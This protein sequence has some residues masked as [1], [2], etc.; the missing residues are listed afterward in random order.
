MTM[1]TYKETAPA[2]WASYLINDDPSAMSEAE[3]AACDAWADRQDG[4]IT[5][6]PNEESFFGSW[7]D[8]WGQAGVRK[9]DLYDYTVIV[10]E[11]G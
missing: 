5:L 10:R 3:I 8:D 9:G 4:D 7:L 6:D 11:K 2:H 1:T